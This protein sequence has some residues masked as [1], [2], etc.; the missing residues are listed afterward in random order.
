[1]CVGW[2]D[3]VGTGG[4]AVCVFTSLCVHVSSVYRRCLLACVCA[5]LCVI[6][7]VPGQLVH[8]CLFNAWERAHVRCL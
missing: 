4:A 7:Y 6:V 5:S 3:V 8:E 1:M 2:G